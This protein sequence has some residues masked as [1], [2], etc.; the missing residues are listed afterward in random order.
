MRTELD[1]ETFEQK[2]EPPLTT[3]RGS[4]MMS[5]RLLEGGRE[6]MKQKEGLTMKKLSQNTLKL[7]D[8]SK[9]L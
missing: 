1:Y 9:E 6:T 2:D 5:N 4:T 3:H 7:K 8:K